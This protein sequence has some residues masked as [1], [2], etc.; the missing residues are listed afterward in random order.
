M[1]I[2]KIALNEEQTKRFL[3]F[4]VED[5]F[6]IVKEREEQSDSKDL[7]AITESEDGDS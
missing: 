5:A 4:F 7:L 6:R 1:A 2:E 3:S